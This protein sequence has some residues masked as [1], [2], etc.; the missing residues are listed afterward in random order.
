MKIL[1]LDNYDS[2]TY[3]LV[4][5]LRELR[6]GEQMDIIRNDKIT[7]ER[8]NQYDKILLSP[9]PGIPEEAGIMMEVIKTYAPSK[10]ILGICL[11]H[12]GIAEA[13][14]AELYNMPLV[15]HGYGG[16]VFIEDD[17]EYLFKDIPKSFNVCRYHS[18]AVVADSMNENLVVTARDIKGEIMGLRHQ[19]Y[20]VK[21][22]QFHPESILTEHGKEMIKNWLTH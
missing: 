4:H 11:G 13:F 22:L 17:K 18:W 9:G 16:K 6:V 15:L 20:D 19:Q 1:V 5:I 10:S 3:N 12:Q 2:F 14:G 7:L 21:G 8:V